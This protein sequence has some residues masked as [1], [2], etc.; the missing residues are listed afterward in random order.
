MRLAQITLPTLDNNG[1]SLSIA[2][3]D[4][5]KELVKYWAGFTSWDGNGAW[6]AGNGDLY[7]EAVK[8][9]QIFINDATVDDETL[10]HIARTIGRQAE[11]LA[12]AIVIDGKPE[13][14]DIISI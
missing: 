9:Y 4:L 8:V 2:H 7:F 13:I 6:Q 12:M 10:R 5:G 3:A 14:I 1:K 11:Q